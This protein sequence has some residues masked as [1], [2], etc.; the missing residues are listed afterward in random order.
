MILKYFEYFGVVL[1]VVNQEGRIH[2]SEI[3][4]IVAIR[5]GV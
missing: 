1:T 5:T 2:A 3:R 4:E